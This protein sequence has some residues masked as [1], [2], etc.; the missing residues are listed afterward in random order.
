MRH[1]RLIAFAAIAA[2]ATLLIAAPL[3]AADQVI[4]GTINDTQNYTSTEGIVFNHTVLGSGARVMA[5]ANYEVHLTPGTRLADGARL[6]ISI[7]D[8]DGLS[9]RCEMT[10]FGDLTHEPDDD[11]DTDGLTNVQECI[12]GSNPN[13]NPDNDADGDG[14]P[15]GW[16]TSYGLDPGID[17]ASL[18]G[19]GDGLT[20]LAEFQADTSPVDSDTDDD[21]MLDG[22]EVQ[23]GLNPV[24]VDDGGDLDSD[25]L[26]NGEEYTCGSDPVDPQSAVRRITY[27]Y[28][29]LSELTNVNYC[30][31]TFITYVY[32]NAGNLTKSIT[33]SNFANNGAPSAL[34]YSFPEN[35]SSGN[36][37]RITLS[38]NAATDP[39]ASDTVFYDL[40][41]GTTPAPTLAY[42]SLQSTGHTLSLSANTTYYWKIIAKDNHGGET[43][44]P[45]WYFSTGS[46]QI[47][48]DFAASATRTAGPVA[49]YFTDLTTAENPIVSWQWDFNNDGVIDSTN[50]APYYYYVPAATPADYSVRLTVS[51]QYGNTGT[52]LKPGCITIDTDEDEDGVIA[53]DDNCPDQWNP[54]QADEDADGIGND[55][56]NCLALQRIFR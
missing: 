15:D 23:Y 52:V 27:S 4:S 9:N 16:E 48:A 33:L 34:I 19:D 42:S 8:N 17:D 56:E 25:G 22:W 50:R 46:E 47:T 31:H 5:T 28:N 36:N 39:D 37:T 38:W 24:I 29:S 7:P 13:Q 18:D 12:L 20:N 32:D 30:G 6:S 2:A 10:Y 45:V 44:G 1:I 55:C 3:W 14:M 21:T 26:S 11:D 40:Y 53:V 43:S 51:D 54:D 49:I 35:G 41:I